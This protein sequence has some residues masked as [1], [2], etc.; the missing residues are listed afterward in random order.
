M[1]KAIFSIVLI[2]LAA[3]LFAEETENNV[4]EVIYETE[5]ENLFNFNHEEIIRIF[6]IPDAITS[7]NGYSFTYSENSYQFQNVKYSPD[8]KFQYKDKGITFI[9][10]NDIINNPYGTYNITEDTKNLHLSGIIVSNCNWKKLPSGLS[11]T[12]TLADIFSKLGN[13]DRY[14]KTSIDYIYTNASITN[15]E[16]LN[17]EERDW[18][19]LNCIYRINIQMKED[20][21]SEISFRK[22]YSLYINDK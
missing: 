20:K 1:K 2:S 7:T 8:I 15:V 10:S 12:D 17:L 18:K 19:G 4:N 13:P 16:K 3:F 11:F 6:G 22:Y 14:E 21:I 9:F 5:L